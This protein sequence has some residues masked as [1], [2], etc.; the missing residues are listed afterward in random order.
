MF[1]TNEI[2]FFLDVEFIDELWVRLRRE[3]VPEEKLVEA[4]SKVSAKAKLGGL[5][6][7]WDILLPDVSAEL[8][9]EINRK[10][11]EKLVLPAMLRALLIPEL[12]QEVVHISAQDGKDDF[13]NPTELGM[14]AKITC[15]N[16][17]IT[18]LP[19]FSSYIRQMAY[20]SASEVN[21][22]SEALGIESALKLVDSATSMGR[23]LTFAMRTD[24][25]SG[26]R[27][28]ADLKNIDSDEI[29][30]ALCASNDDLSLIAS[31]AR[32]AGG[33]CIV[34][35]VVDE[36][37]LRRNM[38]AFIGNRGIS[39]FGQVAHLVMYES[40]TPRLLGLRSAAIS[41]C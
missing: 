39:Y 13:D 3:G 30:N 36:K 14:F 11:S 32:I 34:F 20:S 6:K 37:F 40:G 16:A 17:A 21:V 1:A 5:G 23:A 28:L 22:E 35:S 7:L 15:Q 26:D 41:L 19:T 38:A 18:P 4:S 31:R 12:I 9:G 10:E 2:P 33:D 27:V 25:Q 24:D 29:L 8:S